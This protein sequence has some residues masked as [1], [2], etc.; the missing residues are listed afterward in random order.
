M[1]MPMPMPSLMAADEQDQSAQDAAWGPRRQAVGTGP[2]PVTGD[3]G[4][5]V[6]A[7]QAHLQRHRTAAP[8]DPSAAADD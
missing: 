2:G 4:L 1:P 8:A 6:Q 3:F 5:V 7:V